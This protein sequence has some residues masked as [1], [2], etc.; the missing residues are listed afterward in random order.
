[1]EKSHVVRQDIIQRILN[2]KTKI[3]G[4]PGW[5]DF[6]KA[7]LLGEDEIAEFAKWRDRNGAPMRVSL[8]GIINRPKNLEK[9][10]RD[11]ESAARL[12]ECLAPAQVELA[13]SFIV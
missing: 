4:W 6:S 5:E 1:M 12:G 13:C 7:T 2:D 9:I 11:V 8:I 10:V 3:K